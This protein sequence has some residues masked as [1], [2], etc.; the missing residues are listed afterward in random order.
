[1]KDER[2]LTH[3]QHKIFPHH[4]LDACPDSHY[5]GRKWKLNLHIKTGFFWSP[6][7]IGHSVDKKRFFSG[8]GHIIQDSGSPRS[9]WARDDELDQRFLQ[10]NRPF[11]RP[12]CCITPV[13]N[14]HQLSNRR[15]IFTPRA[16]TDYHRGSFK[17]RRRPHRT[18][19]LLLSDSS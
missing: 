1:M 19:K 14:T 17:V 9:C 7:D 11:G 6:M 15:K 2:N 3:K 8:Y 10:N 13:T 18:L 16:N 5:S 4:F 12:N